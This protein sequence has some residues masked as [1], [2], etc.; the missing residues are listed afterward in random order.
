LKECRSGLLAVGEAMPTDRP[1][2]PGGPLMKGEIRP[3]VLLAVDMARRTN[4]PTSPDK[5]LE[6]GEIASLKRRLLYVMLDQR[7]DLGRAEITF[8]Q[9]QTDFS[10]ILHLREQISILADVPPSCLSDVFDEDFR[11]A[12]VAEFKVSAALLDLAISDRMETLANSTAEKRRASE[13]RDHASSM[14]IDAEAELKSAA[15]RW[16][17]IEIERTQVQGAFLPRQRENEVFAR[18][19]WDQTLSLASYAIDRLSRLDKGSS[20]SR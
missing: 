11:Q 9:E 19:P 17:R 12:K 20:A 8:L 3:S 7:E 16:R 1:T 14:L 4:W 10:R 6:K 18:D 15:A 5:P 2:F 13:L